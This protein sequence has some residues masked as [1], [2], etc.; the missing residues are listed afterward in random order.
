MTARTRD[1]RFQRDKQH[2]RRRRRTAVTARGMFR[3]VG[4]AVRVRAL[5]VVLAVLVGVGIGAGPALGATFTEG[6]ASSETVGTLPVGCGH[7]G[8]PACPAISATINW[9]DGSAPSAGT[10]HPA[11]C[12]EVHGIWLCTLDIVGTHL[13][14]EE[15]TF[16]GTF[17]CSYADDGTPVS[18]TEVFTADVA[19]A[20]LVTG[21]GK[22]NIVGFQGVPFPVGGGALATFADEN[23]FATAADFTATIDWGDGSHATAGVVLPAP[24]GGFEVDGS[25]VYAFPGAETITVNVADVGGST[26]P[27]VTTTAQLLSQPPVPTTTITLNPAAP[28][29]ANNWYR[30][31][32]HATVSAADTG[33]A[34]TATR[35]A[36]DPPNP[37]PSFDALPA[38]PCAFGGAGADV[39]ADGSHD[40]YAASVNAA[41]EVTNVTH[42]AFRIDQTAPTIACPTLE[43]VLAVGTLG[44]SLTAT[45][46]DAVS[47]PASPVVSAA[48]E[49]STWGPKTATFTGSDN[50]GNTASITCPYFVT[51]P[52]L[53]PLPTLTYTDSAHRTFTTFSEM[54]VHHVATG[55]VI[56]VICHGHGCPFARRTANALI[57][58]RPNC[59][60][61]R[62]N[63]QGQP[64]TVDLTELLR[65]ASLAAG[66]RLRVTVTKP[67]TIG[68]GFQLTIRSKRNPTLTAACLA[69][70][71]SLRTTN[72]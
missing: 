24:D 23:P 70:G 2:R 51:P 43:P 66:S 61:L 16:Q 17:T 34:V 4:K 12:Q 20:P 47:G 64:G 52:L 35:C 72:C 29:G 63:R 30:S 69:P 65:R 36:L 56:Q 14:P 26:L 48:A 46:T 41:G 54:T 50:A 62:C 19:D 55:A 39:I 60:R 59:K 37:P 45:V 15:G 33:V 21:T 11:G 58:R 67:N 8:S 18:E 71:P 40:L 3:L 25:H 32:V 44:A 57:A 27:P 9:G 31:S 10:A 5:A 53:Q 22:L 1:L 38:G 49:V 6:I 42:A 7:G 13:Y 28:T 68:R